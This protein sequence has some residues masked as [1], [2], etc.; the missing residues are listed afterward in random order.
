MLMDGSVEC[1]MM[2]ALAEAKINAPDSIL[3][4]TKVLDAFYQIL[5]DPT[6]EEKVSKSL[7]KFVK[8]K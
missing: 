4:S 2:I 3:N 5:I 8:K 6:I 7:F 1:V